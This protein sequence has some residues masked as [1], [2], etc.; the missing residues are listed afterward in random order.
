MDEQYS[1]DADSLMFHQPFVSIRVNKTAKC[2]CVT[3]AF[4]FGS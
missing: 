4:R 3:V 1:L 2:G